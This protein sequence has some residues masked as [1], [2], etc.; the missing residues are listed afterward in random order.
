MSQLLLAL[1][2]VLA[3][4]VPADG[5]VLAVTSD[6]VWLHQHTRTYTYAFEP[7]VPAW[8][9]PYYRDA[10]A[11]WD[12]QTILTLREV[13]WGTGPNIEVRWVPPPPCGNPDFRACAIVRYHRPGYEEFSEA[14][15]PWYPPQQRN[16]RWVTC[17]EIG[18]SLG[19]G[20]GGD[21]CLRT[22]PRPTILDS[23]IAYLQGKQQ[24]PGADD[25][26]LLNR[27]Y[28]ATGH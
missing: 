15:A 12:A 27:T 2:I 24:H 14:Q 25:V 28:P 21:G 11:D 23:E 26:E 17:H 8:F 10:A 5:S 18:H 16:I 3:I 13:P 4:A 1:A 19:L 6:G 22:E 9:K 20:H 7:D